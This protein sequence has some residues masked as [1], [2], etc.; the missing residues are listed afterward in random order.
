MR[1]QY[2]KQLASLGLRV[3]PIHPRS[4]I[5]EGTGDWRLK[6]TDVPQSAYDI[7]TLSPDLNIGVICGTNNIYVI[8]VDE[9][10]N[11]GVKEYAD[12]LGI[13]YSVSTPHGGIHI[14]VHIEGPPLHTTVV[15]W[16]G[17]KEVEFRGHGSYVIGPGSVLE[18]ANKAYEINNE[19]GILPV[20]DI[21][22][23]PGDPLSIW[24]Q[25]EH[26]RALRKEGSKPRTDLSWNEKLRLIMSIEGVDPK[27]FQYKDWI[28]FSHAMKFEL[29]EEAL[30]FFLLF[31]Q[32]WCKRNNR[33]YDEQATLKKWSQLAPD[34]RVGLATI[35]GY[36]YGRGPEHAKQGEDWNS[37]EMGDTEEWLSSIAKLR[38]EN[39]ELIQEELSAQTNAYESLGENGD[40]W[41]NEPDQWSDRTK[42]LMVMIGLPAEKFE[43][44]EFHVP[45]WSSS[46]EDNERM[47]NLVMCSFYSI[48]EKGGAARFIPRC[49]VPNSSLLSRS[50]STEALVHRVF[51]GFP[52]KPDSKGIMKDM[53]D[54]ELERNFATRNRVGRCAGIIDK[55]DFQPGVWSHY[56]SK[57]RTLNTW[58]YR[59]ASIWHYCENYRNNPNPA[60]ARKAY[61]IFEKLA[62][63]AAG[64]DWKY[65]LDIFVHTMRNLYNRHT[66]DNPLKPAQYMVALMSP[67]QGTGKSTIQHLINLMIS[68]STDQATECVAILDRNVFNQFSLSHL[69]NRSVVSISESRHAS[70][71]DMA[72]SVV[73]DTGDQIRIEPKGR[74]ARIINNTIVFCIL[75]TNDPNYVRVSSVQRR[76]LICESAPWE[77]KDGIEEQPDVVTARRVF[78]S[79]IKET[80]ENNL[81]LLLSYLIDH[82]ALSPNFTPHRAPIT[83]AQ[84]TQIEES[85]FGPVEKFLQAIGHVPD[86]PESRA[87]WMEEELIIAAANAYTGMPVSHRYSYIFKEIGIPVLIGTLR[88]RRHKGA[89]LVMTNK[90]AA[91]RG[92]VLGKLTS[93]GHYWA[94]TTQDMTW[95]EILIHLGVADF[96][97]N[98]LTS[99]NA[100]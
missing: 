28:D 8:D 98:L 9:K 48:I 31:E 44:D 83:E 66:R 34:G 68:G 33:P 81:G 56:D 21:M 35:Y 79:D 72:K 58:D 93:G 59:Y 24:T 61:D 7:F 10:K 46:E 26:E 57:Q 12:L 5:P 40:W 17:F 70:I 6:A 39:N 41:L 100:Q 53:S 78:M 49:L 92:L 87:A 42:K 3:F 73:P 38:K 82:Y 84:R 45:I 76:I 20:F 4:K 99:N 71:S 29:G 47:W 27:N 67:S 16:E 19:Q 69:E 77:S 60:A 63:S 65:F 50:L 91:S 90:K 97:G 1:N 55:V 15:E 18:G 43:L 52:R 36:V 96:E 95:D 75:T 89:K 85:R 88:T 80:N 13:P 25:K 37:A 14:Y 62:Q 64:D 2:A 74:D 54:R 86:N 30:P 22:D 23:L 94:R 51:R 32:R 11:P